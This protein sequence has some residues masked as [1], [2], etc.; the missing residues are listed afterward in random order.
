[1]TLMRW[2]WE[3]WGGAI[4]TEEPACDQRAKKKKFR[5]SK[6]KHCPL[7]SRKRREPQADLVTSYAHKMGVL[8]STAMCL[9]GSMQDRLCNCPVYIP[10]GSF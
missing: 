1:M 7:T 3:V 10:S 2:P 8:V 4:L 9:K 6:V 5:S